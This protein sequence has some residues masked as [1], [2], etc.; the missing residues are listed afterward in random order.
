MAL[1]ERLEQ[2]E[3]DVE[4]SSTERL[5][6]DVSTE[7]TRA[8]TVVTFHGRGHDGVGED[9]TYTAEDHEWFPHVEPTGPTTLGEL[10]SALD[11]LELFRR[12]AGLQGSC[13]DRPACT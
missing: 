8:T 10:S 7:F 4:S 1:W 9:V 2:L 11:G 5:S 6:V 13:R 12:A 3:V